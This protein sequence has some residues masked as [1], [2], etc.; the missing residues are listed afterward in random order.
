VAAAEPGGV[1]GAAGGGRRAAALTDKD[2][3]FLRQAL[4]EYLKPYMRG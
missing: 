1:G 4:E 3:E 2:K